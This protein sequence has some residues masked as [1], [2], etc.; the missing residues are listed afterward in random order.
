MA[1]NS[2]R[3]QG[4]SN[5]VNASTRP[6]SVAPTKGTTEPLE[7]ETSPFSI[8]GIRSGALSHVSIK[9]VMFL[10]ILI[11]AA[12]FMITSFNPTQG[13]NTG[14]VN[15]QQRMQSRDAVA[16]VGNDSIERGQ[17]EQIAA[18]Q[19]QMMEQ[20]GQKVGPLEYLASRQ[21]TLQQLADNAA[22]VQ[23]A[24]D[25]GLT[26]SDA[27]IE[28]EIHK[29]IDEQLKSE[30]QQM[31][32]ANFRRQ[33]EA[34]HGSMQAY[35]D[36]LHKLAAGERDNLERSLLVTKLEK[37]VKDE[38]KVTEDDYKRS[39]TKLKLRQIV[40]KPKPSGLNDKAAQ[41]KNKAEAKARAE[42]LAASLKSKPTL[43][44]F[45][46]VAK[47]ESEDLMTKS[48][49]G[50]LGWKLPAELPIGPNVR[51]ELV[52][53]SGQLVGPIGDD[54]SGDQYIFFVEGRALRL[55][56]D[57]AK[58]KA[59]LLKDF[60]TQRDDEAWQKRQAEISKAAT[61]EVLDP[62][63]QAFKIQ[64]EQIFSAPADEQSKLRQ[65]ALQKYEAALPSAPPMEAAAIRYQMAQ[66]YRDLKEPKK[67]VEVL[68]AATDEVKDAPQ[69]QLEYARALRD[70]GDKKAALTELQETSK[71]LD[72]APPSPPSMFGGN[73]D[74]ALRFQL[75]SE[76]DALGRKDLAA[77]ERA[78]V[79]PQG[80]PG[81]GGMGMPGMSFGR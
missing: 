39:Q 77:K 32:E 81:M 44:N 63:L 74:D 28:A 62:A 17:F 14:P 46:A 29:R 49:S 27:E 8:E 56:K 40:I 78:K 3:N 43:Q 67:A 75:S 71:A 79:K 23:A 73:P 1:N 58:N 80:A 20:F 31:G 69:L 18:R 15:P 45:A 57:Y 19:D 36:E 55:P 33:V 30:K 68:K 10:L 54:S 35:Q 4:K 2:P 6:T 37:K 52:K 13:I 70:A 22:T 50:D 25:A 26:V 66:L 48:K 38:N 11:F 9:M 72:L 16:T 51:D 5:Q 53:S 59:K 64:S 7:R 34:Q 47:Q 24:R 76:F 60:E 21:R 61:V 41:E 12:G 65:D 42:K